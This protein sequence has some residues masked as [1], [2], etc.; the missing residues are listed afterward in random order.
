MEG[1][2]APPVG[3]DARAVA[4]F[5]IERNGLDASD[6]H[7]RKAIACKVV[8]V[9]RRQE[10]RGEV[11]RIGNKQGVVIWRAING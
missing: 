7:L 3:I 10:T 8:Q 2:E 4:L 11:S 9:L 6:R 5:V 1:L